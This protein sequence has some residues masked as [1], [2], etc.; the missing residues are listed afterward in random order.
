MNIAINT[1][2][3]ELDEDAGIHINIESK[4]PWLSIPENAEQYTQF[5][6]DMAEQ[7]QKILHD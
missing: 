3:D 4:A 5:P 7:I 1:L 2:D 6:P